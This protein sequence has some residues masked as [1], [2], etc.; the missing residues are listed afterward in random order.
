MEKSSQTRLFYL[1]LK[2]EAYEL[3]DGLNRNVPPKNFAG[4]DTLSVQYA[5]TGCQVF[6]GGYK[7]RKNIWLMCGS[8]CIRNV[9]IG[10]EYRN[11]CLALDVY[12][13]QFNQN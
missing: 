9:I 7:I 6:N 13:G 12:W 11:C 5:Y 3:F 10:L 4:R 1:F 2:F 8:C